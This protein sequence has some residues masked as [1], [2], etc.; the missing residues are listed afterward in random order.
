MSVVTSCLDPFLT[1]VA[2]ACARSA[3]IFHHFNAA[4]RS[5]AKF[6]DCLVADVSGA[7]QVDSV[8]LSTVIAAPKDV[9]RVANVYRSADVFS[10]QFTKQLVY[11]SPQSIEYI[12]CF[13]YKININLYNVFL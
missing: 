1:Q 11:T 13:N 10:I 3:R 4:D 12:K 6:L 8:V 9:T 7:W 5:N 2:V